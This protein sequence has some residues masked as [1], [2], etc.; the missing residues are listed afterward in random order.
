[1]P[2]IKKY[3]E[4]Y[5]AWTAHNIEYAPGQFTCPETSA[6]EFKNLVDICLFWLGRY[7]PGGISGKKIL[8]IGCLE[9]G[10]TYYLA[11]MGAQAT[12]LEVRKDNLGRC[13]FL[14]EAFPDLPMEFIKGDVTEISQKTHGHYDGIIMSGLLYHLDAPDILP[15]LSRLR[16]MT[17]VLLIDTHLAT[18]ALEKYDDPSGL[19]LYG[20]SYWEHREN[21][22]LEKKEKNY[23]SSY[24]NNFS[25]W[26]TEHSLVNVLRKAGFGLTAKCCQ[27]TFTYPWKDRGIWLAAAAP[28]AFDLGYSPLPDPDP[29]NAESELFVRCLSWPANP[30]TQKI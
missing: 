9:G 10:Y 1:M 15:T 29:R 14:K 20:R 13:S 22:P 25:F 8:D 21:K 23:W 11:K 19:T 16:Q 28:E 26:L 17:D 7:I 24:L 3:E 27:P 4:L 6:E 2:D 12:G 18:V 30:L 5:G